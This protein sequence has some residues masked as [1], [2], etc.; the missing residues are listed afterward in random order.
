V[1]DT[2]PGLGVLTHLALAASDAVIGVCPP[3]FMAVRSLPLLLETVEQAR[4]MQP[5]VR[6]LGVVPTFVGTRTLHE[7]ETA[8]HLV[9]HYGNLLLPGI[10]RRIAVADSHIAG[11]PV[12]VSDP[13]S[14]AAV[15][16]REVAEEVMLRAA[17]SVT[18]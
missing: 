17:A 3:D 18:V 13:T 14:V 15:A 10:P 4:A 12:V 2:P 6:L 7:R 5:G 8:A 11:Q 9:D 16:F 1:L